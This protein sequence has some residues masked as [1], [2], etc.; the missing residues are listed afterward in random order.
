M[1]DLHS[2]F[3]V[4][5]TTMQD[6]HSGVAVCEA[7]MQGLHSGFVVIPPFNYRGEAS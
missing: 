3:T 4:C 2:G 6:L 5:E 7:T 1:Q